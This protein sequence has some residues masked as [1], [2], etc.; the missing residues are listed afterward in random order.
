MFDDWLIVLSLACLLAVILGA[1]GVWWL[2]AR[3]DMRDA[4]GPVERIE[5]WT[6][7]SDTRN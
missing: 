3:Q 2:E 6:T 7:W 5:E 1:F 4:R